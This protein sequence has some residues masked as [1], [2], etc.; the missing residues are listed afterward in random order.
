MRGSV[1]SDSRRRQE[2]EDSG[3]EQ[4][5]LPSRPPSIFAGSRA[6]SQSYRDDDEVPALPLPGLYPTVSNL[7]RHGVAIGTPLNNNNKHTP[8]STFVNHTNNNTHTPTSTIF[9]H[10]SNNNNKN[11]RRAR[12]APAMIQL[13]AAGQVPR[14]LSEVT[15]PAD[16]LALGEDDES[17]SKQV[18]T[19]KTTATDEDYMDDDE[20]EQYLKELEEEEERKS[21]QRESLK[22]RL[23]REKDQLQLLLLMQLN[24]G[25]FDE[26]NSLNRLLEE[27]IQVE[28]Q[29]KKEATKRPPQLFC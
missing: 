4:P 6:S 24:D 23:S 28:E 11:K 12:N 9:D 17:E 3:D 18:L 14:F 2:G 26:E 1:T 22:K 20:L 27:Q 15:M 8:T 19:S 5:S 29:Y 16:L 13:P 10:T 7:H 21:H 25:A